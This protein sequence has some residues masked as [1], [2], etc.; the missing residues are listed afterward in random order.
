[1][2]QETNR[3]ESHRWWAQLTVAD[4]LYGLVLGLAAII[5]L[6]KLG[7]IPL[8]PQEAQAA[9]ATWQFWQ[10][11]PLTAVAG[12]PAYFTLTSLLT[13][14]LGIDDAI[15]RLVPALFGVGLVLLPWFLRQ[16][17]GTVGTLVS[18]LLLA[19]SPINVI[20]SRTAGGDSMA[21]FAVLLAV[22]GLLRYRDT[23]DRRWF[24][25]LFAALG[26]GIVTSPL[27]YSGLVTVA[28]AFWL[29]SRIGPFL[30][31][32]ESWQPSRATWRTAAV[33]SGIV[34]LA[35]G[36]L[37]LWYP[38]GLGA[39]ARL[40]PDWIAQFGLQNGVEPIL[41]LGRYEPILFIPGI[42]AITWATWRGHPLASF[43]V[44]WLSTA[45]IL[46][47]LQG[48]IMSN[49]ALLMLPGYLLA[50]LFANAILNGQ[51]RPFAWLLA[52]GFLLLGMIILVN[53][54]RY[55]RVITFDTNQLLNLWIAFVSVAAAIA[56]LYLVGTWDVRLTIQGMLVGVLAIL[57]FYQW[58]TAWWLGQTAANDTRE[59]WVTAPTTD[60][61]LP[62][63][64][65]MI[66]E[67]SWQTAGAATGIDIFSTVDSA[68]LRWYLRDFDHLQIG[69]TLPPGT[70]SSLIITP[71]QSELAAAS[72]Y[73]GTDFGLLRN[74]PGELTPADTLLQRV[75][76][77]LN[78]WLFHESATPA[79]EQRVILWLRADL[80]DNGF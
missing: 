40:L 51:Q 17:L 27:F 7:Y 42:V 79:P 43:F 73:L 16:R 20:I 68:V 2:T 71:E 48:G 32:S 28:L 65:D 38:A 23:A 46:T 67:I 19:A 34:L 57:L 70:Q 61:D 56:L 53:V 59:R 77:M 5:R 47:L 49:A 12:S 54:A 8:A 9:L 4:G 13:Q 66:K 76:N 15:M 31:E 6:V 39:A 75:L 72:D 26:L 22:V 74:E 58:G 21:L 1:M 33:T 10:P 14:V 36:T 69:D 45:L 78:W 55:T 18:S 29:Q 44:Y 63:M 30:F 35:A 60:N 11:E 52:S 25:V 80:D 3:T 37:F 64:V 62:L 24:Y 41:A 50:G